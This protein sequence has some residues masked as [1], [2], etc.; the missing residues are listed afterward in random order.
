VDISSQWILGLGLGIVAAGLGY[1][2]GGLTPGGAVAAALVGTLTMG[3]GGIAPAV[4]LLLFF[5]SS[6]ALSR[7]GGERKIA[8]QSFFSK[9]SRRDPGQVL[10][11]GAV[12]A[13]LSVVFGL[14]WELVWFAG[15]S[16]ALAA[17][18]ADTW[19]TELG[20]LAGGRPWLITTGEPVEAGTSGGISVLGTAAA[21]AGALFIALAG[22]AVA[23]S[24][25]VLPVA[26]IGG[27]AGAQVD[28]LLGA[29]V[30]AGYTCPACGK[31]TERHPL[32]TCGTETIHTRGWRW[33][34]NDAVNLVA[35]MVGALIAI[36][37]WGVFR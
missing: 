20:V 25:R 28:S 5:F 1:L 31:P 32:H 33:L 27:I 21:V 19:A 3:G 23:R 2:I 9:K 36:G 4:L 17:V 13:G 10:A 30:Q 29:T 18:T 35:S 11:N 14:G 34:G 26:L 16:G 12:A 37:S 24:W 22:G 8:A 6:S 15:L 7:I